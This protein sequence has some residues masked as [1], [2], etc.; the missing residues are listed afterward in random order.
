[1]KKQLK[2]FLKK[3]VV[4]V[5]HV[6]PRNKNKWLFGM[7]SAF[8]DN[9][10][11]AFLYLNIY[12]KEIDAI[13]VTKNKNTRDY[14][15]SLGYK[16]YLRWETLG[17]WHGLTAGI[18]L[19]S[20]SL[21]DV[22]FLLKGKALIFN[23]WHGLPLKCL[24][25]NSQ[26]ERQHWQV[27]NNQ[28]LVK[29]NY[30]YY[31][32]SPSD[33]FH[34]IFLDS[35]LINEDSLIE[36]SYPRCEY[37]INID[38]Q[39]KVIVDFEINELIIEAKSYAKSYIYMPTWRDTGTDFFES[40]GFDLNILN[41]NLVIKNEVFFV[42]LHSYTNS[43]VIERFSG[44]S[45]IKIINANVTDVYPFLLHSDCLITDYSSIYF[46]YL[47]LEKPIILFP[48]DIT[49]YESKSRE[50][51][52][53]YDEIMIGDRVN[54][55]SELLFAIKDKSYEIYVPALIEHKSSIWCNNNFEKFIDTVRHKCLK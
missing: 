14:I 52:F 10:K 27:N 20:H 44:F 16:S 34:K 22:H 41:D 18:Y 29:S 23:M 6:A 53:A 46:D 7:E 9:S 26:L 42:K 35:F 24:R 39:K 17:V 5:A 1:M 47:L 13:W 37:L 32:V 11:Y 25:F 54:T 19:Y 28:K 3:I 33:R 45:N 4:S 50:L 51:V 55:F 36:C 48:F 12:H 38:F 43:N 15:R 49:D 31:L 21:H 2:L 8:Y 40:G 30:F